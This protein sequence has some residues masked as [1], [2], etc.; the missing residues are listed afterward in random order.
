MRQAILATCQRGTR[1]GDCLNL[2]K[3]ALN[4]VT[5]HDLVGGSTCLIKVNPEYVTQ[6]PWR[7]HIFCTGCLCGL[8]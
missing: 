8:G 3:L 6:G 7:S 5:V 4:R 1:L 2:R